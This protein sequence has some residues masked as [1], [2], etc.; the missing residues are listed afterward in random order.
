MYGSNDFGQKEAKIQVQIRPKLTTGQL[1]LA[2]FRYEDRT[3][4]QQMEGIPD[5]VL[6]SQDHVNRG[7]CAASELGKF[8]IKQ[9]PKKSNITNEL[10]RWYLY[11]N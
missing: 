6:C 5:Y 7:V 1:A 9:G 4:I 3:M 8:H 11:T 2:I 10:L